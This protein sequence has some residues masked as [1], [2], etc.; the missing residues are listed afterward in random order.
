MAINNFGKISAI[1]VRIVRYHSDER[2]KSAVGKK[3]QKK[4][5]AIRTDPYNAQPLR[6][7]N[8]LRSAAQEVQEAEPP[9]KNL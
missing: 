6:R 9:E 1:F 4:G 3:D 8:D 5:C 7:H 2:E